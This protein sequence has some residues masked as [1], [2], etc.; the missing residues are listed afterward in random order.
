MK[1]KIV[2]TST[3]KGHKKAET[4]QANG[5]KPIGCNGWKVQFEK[6]K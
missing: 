5:W 6:A 3:N 1:Y 2:D 4:L